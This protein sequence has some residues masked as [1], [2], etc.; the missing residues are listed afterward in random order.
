MHQSNISSSADYVES[1]NDGSPSATLEETADSESNAHDREQITVDRSANPYNEFSENEHL[2]YA[3][4]PFLFLL[5]RGLLQTG[6]VPTSSVRHMFFQFHGRFSACQRLI[7]SLFDQL[8]RHAVNRSVAARIKTSP[9]SFAQ[10]ANW[11]T[12]PEFLPRLSEASSN[13]ERPE[14]VSLLKQLLPHISVTGAKA[15]YTAAQRKAAM[16]HLY[17][18]VYHFGVPSVFF[19]FA[20]DDV[21]GVL[22]LRM[23]LPQNN[24]FA[25]PSDGAGLLAA[26]QEGADVFHGTPISDRALAALLAAG[27]IAAAEIYRQLVD[28]IFTNLLGTPPDASIRRTEPLPARNRG[29]FGTPV[30]SFGVTEEQTRGS[31]HMHIVTWGSL[32]PSLLQ[33]TA[34]VPGLVKLIA[35]S[36]DTMFSAT[37]DAEAHVQC[38]LRQLS[39]EHA[40]R[41][42]LF[43]CH[44]PLLHPVEFQ[45]DVERT[46]SSTNVHTHTATYHKPPTGRTQCRLARPASLTTTTGCVQIQ[47]LKH[48]KE[49]TSFTV[50]PEIFPPDPHSQIGRNIFDMPVAAPDRRIIVWELYRPVISSTQTMNSDKNP[51]E[52]NVIIEQSNPGNN[53][54]F[55]YL[56]P[57]LQERLDT[58][59][60]AQH[61]RLNSCLAKRN[62]LVV[63]Y[64]DVISALL[65]CN[66]ATYILGSDA[67]AKAAL[68][69]LLKYITKPPAEISRSL[70]LL[71]NARSTIQTYPSQAEDTG[72][73]QRT[74]QHFLNRIMNDLNGAMEVS[75]AM[76]AAAILGMPSETSSLSFF[77]VFISAAVKFVLSY[78][79]M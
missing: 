71:H 39:G 56:P 68:C 4:F 72:T 35:A 22:N 60:T 67:Q 47:P 44:D 41:S 3:A 10:F 34:I 54:A 65:G 63:E 15:P 50:L 40:P 69:Y 18:M 62:G 11:V 6:S 29:V 79:R 31:L 64:N 9:D 19:T 57:H 66:T 53:H 51:Q 27:P 59:T 70:V 33:Q 23:T 52:T 32:T 48:D 73:T 25:F 58:L 75:G 38:L 13:P 2:L 43:P 5:G 7:F 1:Q 8:Q 17:A 76:A 77:I 45:Q 49:P 42:C 24:N 36:L 28:N 14:S 30:A 74:A 20:P 26:L 21:H 78:K 55:V 37:L 46:I 12:D 61:Q 16:S